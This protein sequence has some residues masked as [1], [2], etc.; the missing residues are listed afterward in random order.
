[1]KAVPSD[2][3]GVEAGR[4]R[5]HLRDLRHRPVER[6][7]EARDLRD[8]GKH[9]SDGVDRGERLRQV[10]GIDGREPVQPLD[11]GWRDELRLGEVAAVDDAVGDGVG[12]PA[13]RIVAEPGEDRI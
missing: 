4:Q 3:G 8:V 11:N 2:A 13:R 1:M 7:V 12:L 9:S 6:G 5:V 10:I